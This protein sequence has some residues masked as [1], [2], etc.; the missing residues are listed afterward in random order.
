VATPQGWAEVALANLPATMS[1]HA[2]AEKKAA[3]SALALLNREPGRTALVARMAK[4]AREEL[5]HLDQV[6][7]HLR[8]RG[9]PLAPDRPDRYASALLGL[10]RRGGTGD[11]LDRLLCAALIEAR[12]WERLRLLGKALA[13]AEDELAVFYTELARSEAGHYRLF[14]DLA[15]AECR[16]EDVLARLGELA[17]AEAEIVLGLPHEPRIH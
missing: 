13:V 1:D 14:V 12:S 15:V 10:R 9:W 6:L 8:A 11:L 2:H 4:L 17:E 7:A 3:L 16:N 5:R